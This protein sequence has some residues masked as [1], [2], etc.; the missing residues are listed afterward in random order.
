[1]LVF[2]I[3]HD[4]RA[5][6]ERLKAV[7]IGEIITK[8]QISA[9]LGRDINRYY[10]LLLSA[11]K[12]VNDELGLVFETLPRVGFRHLP[13]NETH[14]V[15]DTSRGRIRRIAKNANRV[16][17]NRMRTAN[18]ISNDERLRLIAEQSTLGLLEQA[19]R[20]KA[21]VKPEPDAVQPTSYAV[22]AK[23]LLTHLQGR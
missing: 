7:P 4:V 16:I 12:V 13:A 5:I 1:M 14:K 22:A 3:S 15:G 18:D 9:A 11:R 21:L 17:T 8:D 23:A 6:V 10:W 2:N 20:D 19:S